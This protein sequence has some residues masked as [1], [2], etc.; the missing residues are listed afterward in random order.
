[1]VELAAFIETSYPVIVPIV[2]FVAIFWFVLARDRTL[3]LPFIIA[4][5]LVIALS[6]A[7]GFFRIFFLSLPS[8]M[9]TLTVAFLLAGWLSY[10]VRK[11]LRRMIG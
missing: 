5:V 9:V 8:M 6:L 2:A 1:M 4:I 3:L 10:P 7:T 11:A